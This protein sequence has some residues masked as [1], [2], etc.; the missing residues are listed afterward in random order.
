MF[1][2]LIRRVRFSLVCGSVS[3]RMINVQLLWKGQLTLIAAVAAGC[4]MS[5]PAA[6]AAQ[7]GSTVPEPQVQSQAA[8]ACPNES[9][10]DNALGQASALLQQSR[11]QDAAE[12]LQPLADKHCDARVSLLLAAG[13]EGEKDIP[14]AASVLNQA[15]SVWPSNDSI[16]ASLAREY[17][18]AGEPDKALKALAQ[19][20]VTAKTPE[21][22]IEMAVVVYLAAHRLLSAQKL[23][24]EDNK[25][26]P[27]LHSQ[28]LVANTLQMQGRYPDVIRLLAG[29]RALYANSPDFFITLAESEFDASTYVAARQ[30]LQRAIALNPKLYQAHYL[31]GN[32]LAK[33][34]AA[35]GAIA[36][37]RLAIDLA[38]EQ[39]RTYYQLA[40]VL[41]SKQDDAGEQRALE[42]ALAADSRYGPAHCEL[43]RILLEDHRPADAL[44]HLLA[45]VQY[46]PRSEKAYFLLARAYAAMGEKDKSR[47]TVKL[48][49]AVRKE[50]Q[51]GSS[52]TN[53]GISTAGQSTSRR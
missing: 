53:E 50:N 13:Y 51:P 29:K 42:Q 52:N 41:R 10:L 48:L 1:P 12:L 46:N 3:N 26:Y 9:G 39:P 7:E 40:L 35:D 33:I 34:N 23:A 20:H 31:L 37:Y 44:N 19:F 43:G 36:E 25:L 45:A 47:Q 4:L 49:E 28:L 14:K 6:R 5:G 11:F 21:Q 27:S 2:V 22:E 8:G 30:D 17:L 32:V 15:H 24:E 16:A 38:P 18:S